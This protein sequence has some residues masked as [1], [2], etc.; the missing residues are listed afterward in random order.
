MS[1][2]IEAPK[3]LLLHQIGR[4]DEARV[5][6]ERLVPL[7][8]GHPEYRP[9]W[10][11]MYIL[12]DLAERFGD[13]DAGARLAVEQEPYSRGVVGGL[14]T[15]TVWF[16]GNPNRHFGR[17]LALAGRLDEAL[18]AFE[19][20]LACDER[21]GARPDVAL[22]RLE[23]A[24]LLA[25]SSGDRES[26]TTRLRSA[27]EQVRRAA[28]ETPHPGH[29]GSRGAGR[30]HGG[31]AGSG[32]GAGGPAQPARARGRRPRRR[33]PDQPADRGPALPQRTYRREPRPRGADEAG[34]PEPGRADPA[35]DRRGFSEGRPAGGP[36]GA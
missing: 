28:E 24:A 29:A 12:L 2:L 22:G 15:S 32:P 6:Y 11:V 26:R 23:I 33:G 31:R 17:A 25:R 35:G 8:G 7:L 10:P 19:T 27:L 9:W 3:A 4:T 21:M 1:T 34:L 18:E 36:R 30:R 14:G 5:I 16:I 20:A 13:V